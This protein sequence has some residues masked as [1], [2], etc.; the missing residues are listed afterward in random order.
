MLFF[1][2]TQP[3]TAKKWIRDLV[4]QISCLDEVLRFNNL[5]KSLRVRLNGEDPHGLAATWVNV[6]FTF[7]GLKKLIPEE[8]EKFDKDSSFSKGMAA[9]SKLLGDRVDPQKLGDWR[10]DKS[11]GSLINRG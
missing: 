6:A 7:E 5:F 8:A 2:I 9:S 4:P 10:S 1:Q 3:D 11:T